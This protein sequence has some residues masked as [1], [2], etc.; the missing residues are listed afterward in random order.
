MVPVSVKPIRSKNVQA[1]LGSSAD[2]S[3]CGVH[4]KETVVPDDEI[5]IG[6]DND[7]KESGADRLNN[8]PRQKQSPGNSRKRSDNIGIKTRRTNTQKYDN[9]FTLNDIGVIAL[10]I[11]LFLCTI[12]SV[13]FIIVMSS[14]EGDDVEGWQYLLF[15]AWGGIPLLLQV[16]FRKFYNEYHTPKDAVDAVSL[17]LMTLSSTLFSGTFIIAGIFGDGCTNCSDFVASCN[18]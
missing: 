5:H 4:Y 7:R 1:D 18:E 3:A 10:N 11:F 2:R 6:K 15:M 8:R 12:S 16:L 13:V 14:M 17:L 9:G